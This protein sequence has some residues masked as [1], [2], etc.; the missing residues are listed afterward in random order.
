M[1]EPGAG[2]CDL[3]YSF[4]D[5]LLELGWWIGYSSSEE[6]LV[7]ISRWEADWK[8]VSSRLIS[9]IWLPYVF[10]H[11]SMLLLLACTCQQVGE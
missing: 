4:L 7:L 10:A 3:N 2:I 5:L 1:P 9:S 6:H 11:K 8:S